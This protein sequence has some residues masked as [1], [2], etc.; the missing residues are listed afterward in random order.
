VSLKSGSQF[1]IR[2]CMDGRLDY[3]VIKVVGGC[4]EVSCR[5]TN[6]LG[7]WSEIETQKSAVL[8]LPHLN[9]MMHEGVTT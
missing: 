2:I 4:V 7:G 8:R 6:V 5:R 3:L 1:G 9:M